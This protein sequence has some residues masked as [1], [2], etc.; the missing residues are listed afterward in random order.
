[1]VNFIISKDKTKGA[2]RIYVKINPTIRKL[3]KHKNLV[4]EALKIIKIEL[5]L[6]W[7]YFQM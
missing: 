2:I 4:M 1:M 6:L 5:T 7:D 3:Y